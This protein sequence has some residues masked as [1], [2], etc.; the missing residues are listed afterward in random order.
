[1]ATN[2]QSKVHEIVTEGRLISSGPGKYELMTSLFTK[3]ESIAFTLDEKDTFNF[4]TLSIGAEDGSRNRWFLEGY[5][6]LPNDQ[7]FS[8][9]YRLKMYFDS[10]SRGG[11]II[12][13][14]KI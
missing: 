2:T 11:R 9:G 13:Y 5:V 14:K 4:V 7:Y 10:K 8:N 1:M 6:K 12:S 3:G